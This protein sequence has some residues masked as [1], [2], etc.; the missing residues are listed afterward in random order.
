VPEILVFILFLD[1]SCEPG[2]YL[3]LGNTTCAPCRSGTFSLGG[4]IRLSHWAVCRSSQTFDF[5]L[6]VYL[7]FKQKQLVRYH[8]HRLNFYLVND[9]MES[10]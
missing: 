1:I 7:Y 6:R 2:W 10:F 3:P 5:D 8:S 9:A 4:G